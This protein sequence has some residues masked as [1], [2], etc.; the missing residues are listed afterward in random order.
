[1]GISNSYRGAGGGG[2]RDNSGGEGSCCLVSAGMVTLQDNF[3]SYKHLISP[4]RDNSRN[5]VCHVK[6]SF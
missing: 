3:F 4:I 1:M 5:S 2:G 6:H